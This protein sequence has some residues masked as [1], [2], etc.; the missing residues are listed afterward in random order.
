MCN[1][2]DPHKFNISVAYSLQKSLGPISLIIDNGALDAKTG[3]AKL[4]TVLQVLLSSI[5]W[6]IIIVQLRRQFRL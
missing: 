5:Y 3:W 4:A 1:I 6:Y 2:Y